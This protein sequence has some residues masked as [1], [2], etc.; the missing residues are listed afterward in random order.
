M[1]L[2]EDIDDINDDGIVNDDEYV[3]L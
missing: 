1:S 2:T 3:F